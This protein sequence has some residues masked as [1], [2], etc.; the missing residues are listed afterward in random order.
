VAVGKT[1]WTYFNGTW[2]EGDLAVMKAADHGMWLGTL[3]FDGARAFDGLVPDL[4][5]HLQ[6]VNAS[7]DIMGLK[8]THSVAE[9]TSITLEGLRLMGRDKPVYIRPMYWSVSGG[10]GVVVADPNSTAFSLCLEE[11]PMAPATASQTLTTTRFSRPTLATA[12]VNA[13]AACLYPNNGRMLREAQ[14]K[15]FNNALVLDPLGNVAETATAN[16]FMVRNGV[17]MTPVPNGTF[18]NG[19]T[20]QRFI[21]LLRA[22]GVEVREVTLSLDDFRAADE[23]FMSGNISKVT[24]VTKFDDKSYDIGPMAAKARALYWDWARTDQ[25]V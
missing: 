15:G 4:A 13:K 16:I 24:P 22:A 10:P 5:A 3:V 1:I 18:L 6:R 20:R 7:A 25:K 9:L 17:V 2:H 14:G 12:L 11:L 23:V 19:I 21:A 8:P